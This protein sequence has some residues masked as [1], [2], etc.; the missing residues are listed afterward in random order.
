MLSHTIYIAQYESLQVVGL[1]NILVDL[2]LDII[3][4][5]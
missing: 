4:K 1:Y 2:L 5:K 3:C